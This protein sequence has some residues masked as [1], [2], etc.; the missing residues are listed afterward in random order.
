MLE[1]SEMEINK[2][3]FFANLY[4]SGDYYAKEI[5]IILDIP[6]NRFKVY[7]DRCKICGYI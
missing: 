1:K 3:K 7:L 4:K 5:C 2:L 6:Y